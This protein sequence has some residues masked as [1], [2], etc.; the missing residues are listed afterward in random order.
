MS[1]NT[2]D[3]CVEIINDWSPGQF[4]VLDQNDVSRQELIDL[5]LTAY[6]AVQY[7]YDQLTP[8]GKEVAFELTTRIAGMFKSSEPPPRVVRNRQQTTPR[9]RHGYVYLVRSVSS[10]YK[11]GRTRN[12][13][14]RQRT[15]GIQLPFEVEFIALI[16]A[17]DMY[18]LERELHNRF[19][20][21]RI[22]GEWFALSASDVEFIKG[23]AS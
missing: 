18:T 21:K 23:L 2:I 22:N 1:D 3:Q 19:A 20:Q 16:E 12:P 13:E 10:A 15:F 6:A 17:E 11:I 5:W 7:A 4:Y 8:Y 14:D 9:S